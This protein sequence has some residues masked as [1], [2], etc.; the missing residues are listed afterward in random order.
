[1]YIY[2]GN[3]TFTNSDFNSN[4]AHGSGYK[5]Y[6]GGA[7]ALKKVQK[8]ASGIAISIQIVW[9]AM[10][11]VLAEP[12]TLEA[13]EHLRIAVSLQMKRNIVFGGA[14]SISSGKGTFKHCRLTS[15]QAAAGGAVTVEN[16]GRGIFNNCDFN[17]NFGSRSY[18]GGGAVFIKYSGDGTFTSCEFTSNEALSMI[19]GAVSILW[20]RNLF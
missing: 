6:G 5:K 4:S 11:V 10:T 15:N 9:A 18:E 1:M 3:G 2:K 12:S 19:G 17:S 13:V 7:V 14:I 16:G 20:R 8:E